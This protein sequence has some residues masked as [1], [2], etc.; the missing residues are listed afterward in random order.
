MSGCVSA[1]LGLWLAG[2]PAIDATNTM[3]RLSADWSAFKAM[4]VKGVPAKQIAEQTGISFDALRQRIHREHWDDD[5][6]KAE[7]AVA[8]SVTL[9]LVQQGKSWVNRVSKVLNSHISFIEHT[10]LSSLKLKD[11][12]GLVRALETLDR[13]GRRNYGLDQEISPSVNLGVVLHNVSHTGHVR[14]AIEVDTVTLP[15]GE[16]GANCPA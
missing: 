14:S 3:P 11:F 10:D 13:I 7:Q 1:G 12:E 6:T 4:Y 2:W 16:T 8:H 5:V 9:D 15:E